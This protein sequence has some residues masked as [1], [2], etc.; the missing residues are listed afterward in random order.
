RARMFRT[1][2][3][4]V[5]PTLAA[6]PD[7]DGGL[8]A[9]RSLAD[10]LGASPA[11]LHRLRDNPPVAELLARVL[12][13]SRLVGEWLERQP[14]VLTLLS[15]PGELAR[16]LVPDDYRRLA[17]GL[18]RRGEEPA[19]AADALRRLKRREVARI[20]VR[21]LSGQAEF[22]DV[23]AELSGLAEACLEAAVALVQAEDPD[24]EGV[25]LAVIGM[26]KLGGA[27]LGYASDLDVLL[28]FEP[29]EARQVALRAATRLLGTLGDITPE[30]QAFQVDANLRPEGKDGPLA[31]TLE[32]YR[33]YYERWGQPWELQALTQARAVAGDAELGRAFVEAV[34]ELV[35]PER[36]PAERLQA[37]RR[38]KARV[39]R[40]R[41]GTR[42]RAGVRKGDRVDVKLGPGGLS[43]V[44][45]TVQLLALKH[46]GLL[47]GLRRPGT[48][49]ALDACEREGLLDE[50]DAGWLRDGYLLLSRLRNALYL[51]GFHRSDQL[52]PGVREQE[53]VA[54]MLGHAVPG[55]QAL[56]EDLS[57]A[58]RRVR[59]VHERCFY[60]AF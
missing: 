46:G 5:L 55:A 56:V 51:A 50:R 29:A 25:R 13:R 41:A 15:D 34:E 1:V 44:E 20:A 31:R 38:M 8:A 39:E 24:A 37:V 6:A 27:E 30:G 40:D 45:W 35:F 9:F 10:R 17:E 59:K 4:A 16:G 19:G 47:P 48:L 54:R 60:D 36:P 28:V 18:L 22:R 49:S 33:S 58:M 21:D 52:P 2:L 12:G 23:A 57:R 11:F 26:G 3:P 42:P 14:E 53:R 7:P 32:S 43:D